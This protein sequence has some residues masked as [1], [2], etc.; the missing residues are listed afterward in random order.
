MS[1]ADQLREKNPNSA[2]SLSEKKAQEQIFHKKVLL[3][4]DGLLERVI[5]T[6]KECTAKVAQNG[7][8][9]F[10]GYFASESLYDDARDIFVSDSMVDPAGWVGL[11]L[12]NRLGTGYNEVYAI[13]SR[14]HGSE[15]T[16][17]SNP[18]TAISK[19]YQVS[20]QELQYFMDRLNCELKELGFTKYTVVAESSYYRI[21]EIH[22]GILRNSIKYHKVP[23]TFLKIEVSW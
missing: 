12:L 14:C 6:L 3:A 22:H 21:R 7:G 10:G 8:N 23:A 17:V 16:Q 5:K 20:P 18:V 4:F 19:D 15:I 9:F 11:Y 2:S 13:S 1:F